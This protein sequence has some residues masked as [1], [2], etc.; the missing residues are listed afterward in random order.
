MIIELLY[1]PTISRNV[2]MNSYF[3]DDQQLILDNLA[4]I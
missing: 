2:S 1:S 4:P 3:I